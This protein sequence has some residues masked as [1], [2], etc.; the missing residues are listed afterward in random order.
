MMKTLAALALLIPLGWNTGPSRAITAAGVLRA[1]AAVDSVFIDRLVPQTTV[2]G[3]DFAAYLLARLG[4]NQIPESLAINV[5][6]DS[7]R[8]HIGGALRD[9]PPE[10]RSAL[11]PLVQFLAPETVIEGHVS[12]APAGSRAVHFHLETVTVGGVPVPDPFLR[13]AMFDVGR[14]Y[15]ALTKSGRDLFVEIPPGASMRLEPDLIRLLGPE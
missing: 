2:A 4:A 9:F 7:A 1:N 11:G 3:G 10:A 6:V 15:P 13:S 12:L 14:Q 8:I 5:A